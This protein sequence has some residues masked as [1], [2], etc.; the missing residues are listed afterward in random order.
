[1]TVLVP[2]DFSTPA[3]AAIEYAGMLAKEAGA[4]IILFHAIPKKASALKEM[5]L[6]WVSKAQ[7]R[8]KRMANG[9]KR[10]GLPP[11]AVDYKVV[12]GFPLKRA[13]GEFIEANN[14]NL[15]VMGAKGETNA[16]EIWLGA[17]A[18][19]MLEYTALPVIAVPIGA[20]KTKLQQI[21]YASD[22][23]NT[24]KEMKT[25]VPFARLFGAHLHLLHVQTSKPD[26]EPDLAALQKS[27]IKK[28]GYDAITVAVL[29]NPEI[30]QGIDRYCTAQQADL[31]VL[32]KHTRGFFEDL[33]H[34]SITK[35]ISYQTKT[36]LLVV[37][38]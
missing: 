18:A 35:S 10:G 4:K 8:L 7:H 23:E 3:K 17:S 33:F 15:V 29:A 12:Y 31:L 38:D 14:V 28:T 24:G 34:R 36:A 37:K 5:D 2:T 30:E 16:P 9:L 6:Y 13:V 25:L 20:K 19:D 22:L 26:Q 32:F 27:L 21:V 11:S 1:M